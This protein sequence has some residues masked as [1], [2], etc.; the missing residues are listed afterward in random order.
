M[1][2]LVRRASMAAV[3][4]LTVSQLASPTL[5]TQDR[6]SIGRVVAEITVARGTP[7]FVFD[8]TFGA[9]AL[10]VSGGNDTITRIDPATN[11]VVAT[12]AVGSGFRHEIAVGAGGVWVTN[13]DDN[14]VS[15]IDP[16]TN[17]VV[18]TIGSAGF[19]PIGV[20]TTTGAVWVGNHHA[21]PADENSTGSVARIDPG[22][23]Q[24]VSLIPVGAPTFT[25]GPGGMASA[26]GL[27]WVGVPNIGGVVAIDPATDAIS[28]YVAVGAC[29]A[30]GGDSGTLWMPSGG[31][32]SPSSAIAKIDAGSRSLNLLANPGG[33]AWFAAIGFG[34]TWVS[35][36]SLSCPPKCPPTSRALVRLDPITG[37]V[38]GRLSTDGFGFVA[39]G[40]G[41]VWAGM[42][43]S[44]RV[45]RLDPN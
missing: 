32:A 23:N 40:A 6:S 10:W 30:P 20:T 28:A 38:L 44:G 42:G 16:A 27:V 35:V 22:T 4:T 7:G 19:F 15:R 25:G 13:P 5:A 37:D 24:V 14:T 45:V 31:C 36:T 3:I 43:E 17:S 41:S 18:A 12:I 29:G 2:T 34:A 33:M 9:G 21:N 26:G 39:V 8:G 11:A 1:R